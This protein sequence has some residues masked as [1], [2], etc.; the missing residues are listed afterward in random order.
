MTRR[1]LFFCKPLPTFFQRLDQ[2]EDFR[3]HRVVQIRG[4]GEGAVAAAGDDGLE[5]VDERAEPAR[6]VVGCSV[7]GGVTQPQPGRRRAVSG[8][9]RGLRRPGGVVVLAAVAAVG[10]V[11]G[12]GLAASP[13]RR[14][15]RC[16]RPSRCRRGWPRTSTAQTRG[17]TALCIRSPGGF[18][19]ALRPGGGACAGVLARL[20][21][22]APSLRH[23]ADLDILVRCLAEEGR[24]FLRAAEVIVIQVPQ[25]QRACSPAR[26]HLRAA[27]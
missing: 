1:N 22:A 16:R 10:E 5:G 13:P 6:F 7:A 9:R 25:L 12:D 4:G 19:A 21:L 24:R 14:R 18:P 2:E 15:S 8:S 20:F 23:V 3:G 17:R 11:A 26:R 27:P